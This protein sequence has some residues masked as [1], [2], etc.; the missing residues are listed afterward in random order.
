MSDESLEYLRCMISPYWSNIDDYIDGLNDI[1]DECKNNED[2]ENL[3]NAIDGFNL[4]IINIKKV[5][6]RYKDEK[7]NSCESTN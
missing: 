3:T 6:K 5:L 1:I 2:R 7:S 4:V